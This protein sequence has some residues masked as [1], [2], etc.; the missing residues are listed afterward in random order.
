ML[1]KTIIALSSII[2]IF[3]ICWKTPVREI[4][5]N[6]LD[7]Y[8]IRKFRH[9]RDAI[10]DNETYKFSFYQDSLFQNK[11]ELSKFLSG[12]S[13]NGVKQ[14]K[15]DIEI[16]TYNFPNVFPGFITEAI[17]SSY[18]FLHENYLYLVTKS[19]IFLKLSIEEDVLKY[20]ILR[21]NIGKFINHDEFY[22]PSVYGIKDL[23]IKDKK[24]YIS[25][26][27]NINGKVN[28]SI[29][30]SKLNSELFFT[31]FFSSKRKINSSEV[32]FSPIQSGGK[33]KIKEN[34]ILLTLGDYRQRHLSQDYNSDNGKIIEIDIE[35]VKKIFNSIGHRNSLGIDYCLEHDLVFSTDM[36]PAG[37]DEIN[38][39][40]KTK[41]TPNFGWPI[42]SYGYHYYDQNYINGKHEPDFKRRIKDSPLY[43]SHKNFGFIEP[44]IYFKNSPGISD[45]KILKHSDS[46]TIFVVG[47]M[48]E[49]Q[50]H[51]IREKTRSLLF[52][53]FNRIS[54]LTVLIKQLDVNERIRDLAYDNKNKLLYYYGETSAMIGVVSLENSNLGVF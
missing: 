3:I 23:V 24:M 27:E 6:N 7:D 48:G 10:I 41:T 54:G 11:K 43:K 30:Q 37:G 26:L 44:V 25:Y 17:S 52:Y 31:K 20:S 5:K 21:S 19:G 46:N 39:V 36:G 12:N 4:I 29:L 16:I 13:I 32:E 35:N 2:V 40:K 42:A 14:N 49:D 1:K 38:V 28:T 8:S 34:S 45:I 53:K 47:T 15:N 22:E 18:L 50:Y 33:M 9:I 51:E